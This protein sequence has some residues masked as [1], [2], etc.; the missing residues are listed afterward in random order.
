MTHNEKMK[1]WIYLERELNELLPEFELIFG[2]DNLYYDYENVWE[3]IESRDRESGVYLNIS[4]PFNWEKGEYDKPIMITLE[5]NPDTEL[6]EEKIAKMIKIGL[7]CDV[8]AGQIFADK[9]DNPVIGE[10]RMY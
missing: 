7:K 8:F 6:N 10:K 4:R 5:S 3:W 2:V 1:F 9:N